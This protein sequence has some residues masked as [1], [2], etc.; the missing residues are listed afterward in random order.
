MSDH[1]NTPAGVA[2]RQL[3]LIHSL[4]EGD[5]RR[6]VR[7]AQRHGECLAL[8]VLGEADH[9][10]VPWLVDAVVRG[11]R[12]QDEILR[13]F[14]EHKAMGTPPHIALCWT[15]AGVL[16]H[17]CHLLPEDE[18]SLVRRHVADPDWLVI[19]VLA[20]GGATALCLPAAVVVACDQ[21][22]GE[23]TLADGL[24]QERLAEVIGEAE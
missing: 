1:A 24:E 19:L 5:G 20:G 2:L 6:A 7:T 21:R 3:L 8:A 9:D 18:A 16:E 11:L 13:Q 17:A 23:P 4:L 10:A 12:T 14:A 15:A 22:H